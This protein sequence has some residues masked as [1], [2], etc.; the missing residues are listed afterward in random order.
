MNLYQTRNTLIGML[1]T[2]TAAVPLTVS[3]ADSPDMRAAASEQ[4]AQGPEQHGHDSG[5]DTGMLSMVQSRSEL[6]EFWEL[7]GEIE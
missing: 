3:A 7:H 5:T 6:K 1:L 2:A 4:K